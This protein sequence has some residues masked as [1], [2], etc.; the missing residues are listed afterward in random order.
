MILIVKDHIQ[1]VEPE[2]EEGLPAISSKQYL[3][4]GKNEDHIE[5]KGVNTEHSKKD[6]EPGDS[7]ERDIE[8]SI[9]LKHT[10]KAT[11]G[12][13]K[14]G[15]VAPEAESDEKKDNPF[16]KK[17]TYINA[18]NDELRGLGYSE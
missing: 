17:L 14:N 5:I 13:K 12:S 3:H 6:P 7:H 11:N 10:K 9:S 16:E 4:T 15:K 18:T 2:N 8:E 1:N